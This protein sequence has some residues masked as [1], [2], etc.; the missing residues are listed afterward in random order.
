MAS[1]ERLTLGARKYDPSSEVRRGVERGL[2]RNIGPIACQRA[3]SMW[4]LL[5]LQPRPTAENLIPLLTISKHSGSAIIAGDP[6]RKR[7]R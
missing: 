3:A 5:R 7:S 6:Y 2:E 4:R 1:S